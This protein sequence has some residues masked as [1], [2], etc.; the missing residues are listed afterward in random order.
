[1]DTQNYVNQ[2]PFP[3]R[4]VKPRLPK[5]HTAEEVRGYADALEVWES[6][7][8]DYHHQLDLY[9]AETFRLENQFKKDALEELGLTDHPKADK[10]YSK[11]WDQGHYAGLNEVWVCLQ[12]L[13]DLFED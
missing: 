13:A 10:I 3:K 4:P 7:Q 1:M 8:S 9:R 5:D 2:M 12:N 6:L 11:A